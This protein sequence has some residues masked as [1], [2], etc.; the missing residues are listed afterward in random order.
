MMEQIR[1]EAKK[2]RA[3]MVAKGELEKWQEEV[4]HTNGRK[5]AQ[6]KGKYSRFSAAHMEEFKKMDSIINHPS[7][8]RAI[9]G[10]T[11]PGGTTPAR[12]AT[13]PTT[14]PPKTAGLKRTKSK[15]NLDEPETPGKVATVSSKCPVR[16]AGASNEEPTFHMKRAK[17]HLEDDVST[18]R[19]ASGNG[20]NIPRPASSRNHTTGLP[21]SQSNISSHLFTPT[22]SS[23]AKSTSIKSPGVIAKST[24]KSN[25]TG[26]KKSPAINFLSERKQKISKPQQP[27]MGTQSPTGKF[28]RVKSLLHGKP[29]TPSIEKIQGSALPLP[30]TGSMSR[31]P[32]LSRLQKDVPI[33]PKTTPGRKLQKH[34]VFM[35]EAHRASPSLE[36][37]SPVNSDVL[38]VVSGVK[39]ASKKSE[40]HYPS[41]DTVMMEQKEADKTDASLYPVLDMQTI[42]DKEHSKKEQ[43]TVQNMPPKV[44]G[45]FTFRSDHTIHFDSPSPSGFGAS[46]GQAS[47]RHVRPSTLPSPDMPGRFPSSLISNVQHKENNQPSLSTAKQSQSLQ[48][49]GIPHGMR[50]KKRHRASWDEE[51]GECEALSRAKKSRKAVPE[52]DALLRPGMNETRLGFTSPAKKKGLR[53]LTPSPVKKH[54]AGIT[55]SRL[56]MLAK[57]KNRQ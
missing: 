43:V 29:A 14:P 40:M 46:A 21:R 18:R 42:E 10:R 23:L 45:T 30:P 41:L 33:A 52:G 38:K 49:S 48:L 55:T 53:A 54:V 44:P 34:V 35:P 56:N 37:P 32:I 4:D 16:A 31:K 39:I 13:G 28:A 26:P 1:E 25:L 27:I 24:P 15:A 6:P 19:P 22:K 36:S 57:P 51:D 7:A 8:F 50:N 2:I 47:L 17:K 11:T 20:S 12:P 3:G 5:M 9:T